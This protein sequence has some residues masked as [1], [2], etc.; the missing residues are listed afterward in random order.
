WQD[1]MQVVL[2][3]RAGIMLPSTLLRKLSNYSRKNRLYQA[4]R[5]LG[6]VER[7]VFL[8]R[9]ITE[10]D[11]HAQVVGETSKL[12]SFHGFTDFLT[13]GDE[14]RIME[15][16]PEEQ[17][18]RLKYLDVLANAVMLQ[19]VADMADVLRELGRNGYVM[20][21]DTVAALSPYPTAHLKRFGDYVVGVDSPP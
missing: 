7:T 16:T 17:D 6:R 1:L 4:F 3:L 21:A 5:E 18:K 9:Y 13:F 19:T 11:T 10:P 12:E 15:M 8:L 14:D 20:E 2:S